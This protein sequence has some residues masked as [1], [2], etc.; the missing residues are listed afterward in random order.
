MSSNLPPGCRISDIPGNRPGDDEAEAIGDA[1]YDALARAGYR[2]D[3][4]RADK[5]VEI[6]YDLVQTARR[7]GFK[8][9]EAETRMWNRVI[10]FSESAP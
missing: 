2:I 3:T 6:I 1:I 8:E 9:G 10:P 4:A 7:D 5:A